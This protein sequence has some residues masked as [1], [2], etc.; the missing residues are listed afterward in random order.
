M[1]IQAIENLV[2]NNKTEIFAFLEKIVNINSF[3]EN[4]TGLI[5]TADS[6]V[7]WGRLHGF[8]FKKI[9]NNNNS[10][11]FHLYLEGR[12]QTPYFALL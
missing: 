3:S 10:N 1:T 7:D 5:Q 12:S 11:I 4:D 2:E 6:I 8:E 9:K